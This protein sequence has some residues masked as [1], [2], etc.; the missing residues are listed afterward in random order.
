MLFHIDT[1]TWSS[2]QGGEGARGSHPH[3]ALSCLPPHETLGEADV[4]GERADR[5]CPQVTQ[6]AEGGGVRQEE[7]RCH[8]SLRPQGLLRSGMLSP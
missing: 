4:M 6:R 2:G 1:V 7:A 8:P 5:Q 3:A